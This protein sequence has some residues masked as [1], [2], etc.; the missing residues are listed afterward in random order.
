MTS[1]KTASE[2]RKILRQR[3]S[4]WAEKVVIG[5]G[6]F[7]ENCG[8]QVLLLSHFDFHLLLTHSPTQHSFISLWGHFQVLC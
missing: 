2:L 1:Q 6:L 7:P 5:F 3:A 4:L 8:I